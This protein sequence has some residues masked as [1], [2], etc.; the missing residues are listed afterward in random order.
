VP[1]EKVEAIPPM[2]QRTSSVHIPLTINL[3]PYFKEV[4][5]SL[6]KSFKGDEQNCEGVSYSY[7]FIRDPIQFFTRG[8]HL[9]YEV[10]GKY[11]LKLNYCPDCTS[12]FDKQGTCVVPR[13]YVSCGVGEPMRKVKVGYSTYF[14]ITPDLKFSSQTDLKKFETVDPCEITVF[15]YDATNKLKKE[16]TAV[17][18]EL[19]KDID[20]E[21]GS[22]DLRTDIKEIWKVIDDPISLGKYGY[23]SIQPKAISLSDIQF[24]NQ[25]ALVFLNLDFQPSISTIKPSHV[26]KELPALSEYKK[27]DGFDINLE[28]TGTYDSL[29]SILNSQ[30]SGKSVMIKK[31]EVIFNSVSIEGASDDQLNLKVDFGGKRKGTLYLKGKPEFDT[32]TQIISFPDLAFDLE[33]K[34]TLL[35]SAKWLF[36]SK[37]TDAIRKKAIFDLTPQ[38]IE[39]K[40]RIQIE[41]NRELSEGINLKGNLHNMTVKGMYPSFDKLVI[42]LNT[43]GEV[44]ITM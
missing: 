43:Q 41:M 26:A 10:D 28:I 5:K 6:D 22:I 13:I 12:L 18:E 42:R 24:V 30:L 15:Q 20:K 38:L 25:K 2:V 9:Y 29:N 32:L 37:I 8:D 1:V 3:D 35:K 44:Y 33:T 23:L 17:L 7:N 39:A 14:K 4:E 27:R 21:I 31:N 40:K 11:S 16:V 36:N 34:N 19:E